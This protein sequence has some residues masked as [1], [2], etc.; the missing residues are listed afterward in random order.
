MSTLVRICITQI[1]SPEG[2]VPDW[3]RE[4]LVDCRFP[5]ELKEQCTPQGSGSREDFSARDVYMV[6]VPDMLRV[7]RR[8]RGFPQDVVRWLLDWIPPSEQEER[9]IGFELT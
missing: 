4:A 1:P 6:K 3:V 7:L 2:G 5:A 9:A 8:K